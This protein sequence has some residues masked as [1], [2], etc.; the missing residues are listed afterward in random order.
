MQVFFWPIFG[1]FL[2]MFDSDWCAE[3]TIGFVGLYETAPRLVFEFTN[4][5]ADAKQ[6]AGLADSIVETAVNLDL[7]AE[8][9]F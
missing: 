1:Y 5:T 2:N 3:A 8:D 6:L 4:T 7:A 9:T